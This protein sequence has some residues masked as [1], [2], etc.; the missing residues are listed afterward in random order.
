MPYVNIKITNEGVTAE[1][2]RQLIEGVTQLLV[3][4]LN[5]NP[6]TTVVVIDEVETDN[7]GIG[8][9]PVTELR[10]ASK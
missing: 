7:W 3:D 5:K 1:Q 4:V 6:K 10:K 2:K 8:G 9:V